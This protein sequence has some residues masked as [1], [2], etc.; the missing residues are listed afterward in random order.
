MKTR[1]NDEAF[2]TFRAIRGKHPDLLLPVEGMV[3]SLFQQRKYRE[4]VN[5]LVLL[6]SRA[7]RN[8]DLDGRLPLESQRI[9]PWAG[10]LREFAATAPLQNYRPQVTASEKIDQ[11]ANQAGT[12]VQKLYRDGLRGPAKNQG[13]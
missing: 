3:W 9:L 12:A 4:A 5:G 11:A 6:V 7:P 10:R 1:K 2:D 13:N 8:L